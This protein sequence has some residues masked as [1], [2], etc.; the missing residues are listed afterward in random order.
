MQPAAA[1]IDV[2][3]HERGDQDTREPSRSSKG[4]MMVEASPEHWIRG[5]HCSMNSFHKRKRD[6]RDQHTRHQASSFAKVMR[7]RWF[8]GYQ[9]VSQRGKH[10]ILIAAQVLLARQQNWTTTHI[11]LAPAKGTA[12]VPKYTRYAHATSEPMQHIYTTFELNVPMYLNE[13]R[14]T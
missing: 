13:R 14:T 3:V 12:K 1:T 5:R 4:Y 10:R 2:E 9:V 6:A 7:F 11:N 8:T